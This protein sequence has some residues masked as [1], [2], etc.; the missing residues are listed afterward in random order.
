MKYSFR[1]L[2]SNAK[3]KNRFHLRGSVLKV[4]CN[5]EIQV[6][7][8]W[9]SFF[10]VR[11]GILKRICKTVLVNSGLFSANYACAYACE[12]V[13]EIRTPL[14]KFS[15]IILFSSGQRKTI[16]LFTQRFHCSNCELGKTGLLS[17]LKETSVTTS[18]VYT[19]HYH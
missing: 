19:G 12:T 15:F 3:S 17:D 13:V 14:I 7:I 4:D 5:Y 8:S 2:Q 1:I 16:G 11:L 9:I 18:S 10:T 6:Q